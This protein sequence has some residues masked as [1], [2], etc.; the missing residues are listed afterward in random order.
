METS[1]PDI[2]QSFGRRLNHT[3]RQWRQVVNNQLAPFGLTEATWLPLMHVA[4]GKVPMR[5][6]DLAESVGIESS[7]LVRLVDALDQAGLIERQVDEDRRV[8]NIC[9]TTRGRALVEQMEAV[10]AAVRRQVLDGI[11][12]EELAITLSVIDRIDAALAGV[13][14]PETADTA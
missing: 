4:R 12:D 13:R 8:K 14:A 3:A 7:T 6:K 5:Q 11:S 1:Q 2:R 10:T 9:L